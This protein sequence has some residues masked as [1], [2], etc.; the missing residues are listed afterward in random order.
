M[1]GVIKITWW[2]VNGPLKSEQLYWVLSSSSVGR[3]DGWTDTTEYSE[4]TISSIF[5][6]A[7]DI[8]SVSRVSVTTLKPSSNNQSICVYATR[9]DERGGEGGGGG[10]G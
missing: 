9:K 2:E 7:R 1:Y 8:S 6:R 4:L 10:G 3:T 5:N